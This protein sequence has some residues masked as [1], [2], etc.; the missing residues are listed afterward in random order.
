MAKQVSLELVQQTF[1]DIL[2]KEMSYDYLGHVTWP[3]C[4]TPHHFKCV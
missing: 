1:N 2:V 3:N 4:D